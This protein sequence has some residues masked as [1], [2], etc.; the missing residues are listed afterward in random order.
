VSLRR[1]RR[2]RLISE[3]LVGSSSGS[4]VLVV[5][6][7]AVEVDLGEVVVVSVSV[8]ADPDEVEEVEVAVVDVEVEVER[9][10]LGPFDTSSFSDGV[11]EV[12]RV[13]GSSVVV[14]TESDG[15]EE[16]DG[17]VDVELELEGPPSFPLAVFSLSDGVDEVGRLAGSSV[18]EA[19]DSE[20]VDDV[21]VELE[22]ELEL[23]PSFPLTILPSSDG[24]DDEVGKSVKVPVVESPVVEIAVELLL[25]PVE[26]LSN[27]GGTKDGKARFEV[28][29]VTSFTGSDGVEE[30]EGVVLVLVLE[31]DAESEG[32]DGSVEVV[33]GVE[34]KGIA[35]TVVSMAKVD[36]GSGVVLLSVEIPGSSGVK[37]VGEVD[38][39]VELLVS[40]V[41]VGVAFP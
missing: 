31:D 36:D 18:V 9:S 15:S 3:V 35:C 28:E 12:G 2:A 21:D 13:V 1:K 30:I 16:V 29:R 24:I 25:P 33:V 40:V 23:S 20:E 38:S 8:D 14:S 27:P 32:M 39:A 5:V 11:D 22:L 7:S 26:A 37:N 41:G 34:S 19:T 6:G 17:A 4:F 10:S